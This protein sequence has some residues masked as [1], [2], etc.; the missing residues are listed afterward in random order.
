MIYCI[1]V[2]PTVDVLTNAIY[3]DDLPV[4]KENIKRTF[5]ETQ[6]KVNKWVSD[7]KK[8]IDGDDDD[9]DVVQPPAQRYHPGISQQSYGTR[10]SGE[11]GRRSG[12]RDRYDADPR[13]LGDDL[14]GLE[15]RDDECMNLFLI[16][17]R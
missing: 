10:R 3:S 4:I 14:T 7:L 12:D 6:S 8:K 2:F 16:S 5:F 1:S 15:L 17:S 13:V 9:E 11:L